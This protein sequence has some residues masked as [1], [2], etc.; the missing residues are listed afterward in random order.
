M[1]YKN[2]LFIEPHRRADSSRYWCPAIG[3]RART[4]TSR[5][6]VNPNFNKSQPARH[7][8][9]KFVTLRAGNSAVARVIVFSFLIV[10]LSDA[11]SRII[12][13]INF[14]R[15][16]RTRRLSANSGEIVYFF[17]HLI[18]LCFFSEKKKKRS[19]RERKNSDYARDSV[20]EKFIPVEK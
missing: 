17:L 3:A 4:F 14:R 1:R 15:A 20:H 8:P 13:L 5:T 2:G 12:S 7:V 6:Y 11:P 16:A 19:E 18:T 10:G 9:R